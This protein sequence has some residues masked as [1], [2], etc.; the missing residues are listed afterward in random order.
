MKIIPE[1]KAEQGIANVLRNANIPFQSQVSIG[2][3]RPDFLLETPTGRKIIIETKSWNPTEKNQARA[4][5]QAQYYKTATQV[6]RVFIVVPNLHQGRPLEGLLAEHEL[7]SV[8]KNE[9]QKKKTTGEELYI[10]NTDRIIFASMP[11]NESYDDTYFVAL[12]EAAKSVDAVCE[13]VDEKKFIGDIVEY[14]KKLIRDSFAVIAD[15]SDSKLNV[16]YEVGY[17]HGIEHPTILI[18]STP[19]T[20]VPFFLRNLKIIEYK[21]GQTYKLKEELINSLSSL[22]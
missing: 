3:V 14:S 21:K 17:A 4:I 9:F 12:V 10:S 15:L 18:C 11:Y 8:L 13:R 2:G 5:N 19:M 22:L 16:L 7:I 1:V 20:S 6:D